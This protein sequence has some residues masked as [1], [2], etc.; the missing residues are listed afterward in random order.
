MQFNT[1]TELK[2]PLFMRQND[3]WFKEYLKSFETPLKEIEKLLLDFNGNLLPD[4]TNWFDFLFY[5]FGSE[6][7]NWKDHTIAQKRAILK[8]LFDINKSKGANNGYD[9]IL[10]LMCDKSLIM[11]KS[12]PSKAY[13]GR[14][15]TLEEKEYY[16]SKFPEARI[17]HF[18]ERSQRHSLFC[19]GF[20]AEYAKGCVYKTDAETR[21]GKR[22]TL[23]DP[24]DNQEVVLNSFRSKRYYEIRLKDKRKGF[25]PKSHYGKF[26][27]NQEAEK[28]FYILDLPRRYLNNMEKRYYARPTL[29]PLTIYYKD[30]A[31]QSRAR[32]IFLGYSKSKAY[33]S[34][35]NAEYRIF[36]SVRIY[37]P[38]RAI[39]R[40]W[41]GQQ[42]LGSMKFGP[43]SK[44]NIEIYPN[45]IKKS[46]QKA[47]FLSKNIGFMLENTAKSDVHKTLW[48]LNYMRP[49]GIKAKIFINNHK[50][51]KSSDAW[52]CNENYICDEMIMEV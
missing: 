4:K 13:A 1:F 12:P 41:R 46:P 24:L 44:Y 14:S 35:Q 43:L 48:S 15:T 27:V 6:F 31:L 30:N 52:L 20:F 19:G 25:F 42:F 32:G 3:I 18:S 29:S 34:K 45:M 5:A 2:L 7:L 36:K 39:N 21:V 11:I 38:D 17:Y 47:L 33:L 50:E 49:A 28:R 40:L 37:A 16:E 51:R 10:R 26:F 22:V 23:F 8:R 9:L